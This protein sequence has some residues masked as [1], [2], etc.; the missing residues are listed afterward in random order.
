MW[1]SWDC[2]VSDF[3]DWCEL[4][5]D[6]GADS[7]INFEQDV[8]DIA[9]Q[10][11]TVPHF[12]D[13]RQRLIAERLHMAISSRWPFLE[14]AYCIDAENSYFSVNH[15]PVTTLRDLDAI[16]GQYYREYEVNLQVL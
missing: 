12:G 9:R 7:F 11:P 10:N 3:G 6:L 4:L 16:L 2:V 5:R 1:D 15:E 13:I 8:W 14:V